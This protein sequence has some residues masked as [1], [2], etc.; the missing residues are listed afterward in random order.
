MVFPQAICKYIE[1]DNGWKTEE[2][3]SGLQKEEILQ[4]SMMLIG[5]FILS[6]TIPDF[7]FLYLARPNFIN[8][9]IDFISRIFDFDTMYYLTRIAIGIYLLFG[10]KVLLNLLKTRLSNRQ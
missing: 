3:V 10:G 8:M 6:S 1:N 2:I 7:F 9:N 4:I 5:V